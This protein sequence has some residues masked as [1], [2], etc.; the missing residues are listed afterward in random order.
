MFSDE[1]EEEKGGT[2]RRT[3]N[4]QSCKCDSPAYKR[5]AGHGVGLSQCADLTQYQER[6][7][8]S[9][10]YQPSRVRMISHIGV[11]RY[12]FPFIIGEI[13]RKLSRKEPKLSGRCVVRG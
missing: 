12:L 4:E 1:T 13:W 5:L 9:G 7:L 8:F 6:L 11:W 2:G 3:G 10:A